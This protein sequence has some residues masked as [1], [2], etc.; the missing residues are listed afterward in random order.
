VVLSFTQEIGGIVA[1]SVAQNMF[2]NRLKRN[3]AKEVPGLDPAIVLN[4]GALGIIN[5]VPKE[6]AAGVKSAYNDAIVDVYYLALA[7][8]CLTVAGAVFIEWKSV[9]EE[10]L[11]GYDSKEK[12]NVVQKEEQK[13]KEGAEGTPEEGLA[14]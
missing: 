10:K 12:Q 7:L 4:N 1:L 13:V 3:L 5:I 11:E 2:T 14:I 8:T 6:D 9:R